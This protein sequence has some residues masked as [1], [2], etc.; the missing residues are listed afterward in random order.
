MK[1]VGQ[2]IKEQR[3]KKNISLEEL[4]EK[5]KIKK[6]FLKAIENE[7]WKSLPEFPVV[8]GFVKNISGSLGMSTE[9]AAALLK[10]DFPPKEKDLKQIN[11]KPDVA[12]EFVWSPKLTFIL[13]IIIVAIALFS[14]LIFQYFQFISPPRLEVEIPKPGQTITQDTI[15][16]KGNADPEATVQVNNQPTL[17]E[18]DGTFET[19]IEVSENTKEIVVIAK[20]RAGKETV[21]NRKIEVNL[22][23]SN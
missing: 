21:I 19:E 22:E 1:P 16:V 17:L 2:I 8:L 15:V 20:S 23:N 6:D 14:Y 3:K 5:T 9:R 13:G 12:R 4:S 7:N 18:A 11:P 10:R